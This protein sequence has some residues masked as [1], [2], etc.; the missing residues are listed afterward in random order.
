M[1]KNK[2]AKFL[3]ALFFAAFLFSIFY[4]FWFKVPLAV[5]A[6]AYNS[7]AWNLADGYGYR[8]DRNLSYEQ[9]YALGR[10]GPGYEFLL[11]GIY[12]LFGRPVFWPVI[13]LQSAFHVLSGV[14]IVLIYFELFGKRE[15]GKPLFAGLSLFLFHPDLVQTNGML[16]TEPLFIFLISAASY[17]IFRF[18]KRCGNSLVGL[19]LPAVLVSFAV[20]VRPVAFLFF[21]IFA[22]SLLYKKYWKQAILVFCI[23]AVIVGPWVFRNYLRH[24]ILFTNATGGMELW[25][26]VLPDSAGEFYPTEEVSGYF[27]KNGLFKT[28]QRGKEEFKKFI[29]A[30]PGRFVLR[31]FEKTSTYFSMLRTSG[32]WLYLSG[33]HQKIVIFSSAVFNAVLFSLGLAG[34]YL[35]FKKRGFLSN[36]FLL[37]A[38]SIPVAVIPVVVTGR[39]RYPLLVFLAVSAIFALETIWKNKK[40]P[41]LFWFSA[42]LLLLNSGLDFFWHFSKVLSHLKTIGF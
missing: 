9:D 28:A 31:Q 19:V 8:E 5:D 14:F 11:A 41:K 42:I 3:V 7:I 20:L 39:Y 29:F 1:Q 40:I 18:F 27:E 16:L 17:F 13:V 15:V 36:Q 37:M 32:F 33:A 10:A 26:S 35:I 6:K 2:N 34:L 24:K 22:V 30:H 21:L 38:A 23:L 4:A 25:V 12:L